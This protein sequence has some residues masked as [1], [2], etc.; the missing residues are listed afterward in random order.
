M[1]SRQ[2]DDGTIERI[3]T[4]GNSRATLFAKSKH[5]PRRHRRRGGLV[6]FSACCGDASG[7][8]ILTI[9]SQSGALVA[10]VCGVIA[11]ETPLAV[12]DARIYW[13]AG[14]AIKSALR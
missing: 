3:A 8:R 12:D 2:G 10:T 5:G 9:D 11:A 1:P 13:V 14:G 6:Y 7:A 4:S